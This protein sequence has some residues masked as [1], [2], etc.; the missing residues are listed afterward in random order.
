DDGWQR[1]YAHVLY[2]ALEG[3]PNSDGTFKD[4]NGSYVNTEVAIDYNAG[5]TAALCAFIDDY[6]GEKLADFPQA[7]TPKWAEWKMAASLNGKGDSYTEVKAWAMNHTAWPTRVAKNIKFRYYF[8][9]SE[10]LAAGL[11]VDNITVSIGSQQYQEGKQGHAT[12][13][14]KPIKYE[15]DPS[16]NTYYAEIVFEDGRAIMPTGQSEH[17]D[18]VQFRISIPD[19]V[20]GKPT[21]GAWDATNDW[22]YEGVEDAPNKLELKAAEN[23]HITMYVDDV[24]VWGTEPDGTKPD[25]TSPTNPTKPDTSQPSSSGDDKVKLGDANEDGKV[26]ISDAVLIMQSIANPEEFKLTEEGKNNADVA[27]RG[28]GVTGKDALAIQF[29]EIKAIKESDLPLTSQE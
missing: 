11:S 15:G 20:D 4:D 2:G 17:R 16:G 18:E 29:V 25:V 28:N 7:E 8:D 26:N 23:N 10:V 6:G 19:A 24:L 27:D 1:E 9:V 14:G 5:Y 12:T 3:G 13:T 21:K 22:S